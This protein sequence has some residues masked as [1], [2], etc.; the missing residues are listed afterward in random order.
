MKMVIA[1][2][3]SALVNIYGNREFLGKV[4]IDE[5]LKYDPSIVDAVKD[6]QKKLLADINAQ[7]KAGKTPTL[8]VDQLMKDYWNHPAFKK[9][10]LS[11][12]SKELSAQFASTLNP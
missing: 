8:S 5:A 10:I 12:V 4:Y 3:E 7:K 1:V 6:L 9:I 11:Q 2:C